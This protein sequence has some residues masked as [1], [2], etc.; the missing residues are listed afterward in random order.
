MWSLA[1]GYICAPIKAGEEGKGKE[2]FSQYT[3][4]EKFFLTKWHQVGSESLL[5]YST[6]TYVTHGFPDMPCFCSKMSPKH[7][8]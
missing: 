5:N 1:Y 4:N 7:I 6:F 2:V 3:E 8:P